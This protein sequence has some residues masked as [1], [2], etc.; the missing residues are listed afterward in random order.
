M[1]S[2]PFPS[3]PEGP[4]MPRTSPH[5]RVGFEIDS[6]FIGEFKSGDNIVYNLAVLQALYDAYDS[7][8][9]N[10]RV[11]LTK[12]IVF[13]I[14]CVVEAVLVDLALRILQHTR[15]GVDNLPPAKLA[16]VRKKVE[17]SKEHLAF[18]RVISIFEESNVFNEDPSFYSRLVELSQ[19]RNRI[20]ISNRKRMEPLNEGALFRNQAKVEAERLCEELV[21]KLAADFSRGKYFTYVEPFRFPWDSHCDF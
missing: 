17:R 3:R 9:T 18:R 20:H 21:R 2:R 1:D 16:A 11:L 10:R 19:L 8:S 14:A 5:K 6:S 4:K 12:P 7:T 13:Q 15:E